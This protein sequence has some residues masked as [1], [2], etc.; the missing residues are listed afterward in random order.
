MKKIDLFRTMAT[1]MNRDLGI[2]PV[3][4][5]SLG[6]ERRLGVPLDPDDIDMLVPAVHIESR[7]HAL[8]RLM[9]DSGFTLV[10]AAE[11]AFEKDGDVLAF[12]LVES[13]TPF[14]GVPGDAI[15]NVY[16]NDGA[17]RLLDLRQYLSVY[18]ASHEDGYRREKHNNKDADKIALIEKALA[19]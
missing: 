3:L 2:R 4:F 17:Y 6:L 9:E 11:H 16:E 13:L 12:A 8:K 10:V 15:P 1:K 14:A 18:K 19:Q 5:G 7:W